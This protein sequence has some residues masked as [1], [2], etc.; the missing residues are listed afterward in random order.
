MAAERKMAGIAMDVIMGTA[1]HKCSY[2]EL[3]A[4]I[5][6]TAGDANRFRRY[7][8]YNHKPASNLQ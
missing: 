1:K 8:C 3:P 6:Q 5:T 7:F 2:C 4:T